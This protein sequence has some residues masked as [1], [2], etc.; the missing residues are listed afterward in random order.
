MSV[1]KPPKLAKWHYKR[2]W[3]LLHTVED[4]LVWDIY[5]A[6]PGRTD[7]RSQASYALGHAASSHF[8]V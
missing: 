3:F 7:R 4:C 2:L 8:Y 5:V 1:N 6:D